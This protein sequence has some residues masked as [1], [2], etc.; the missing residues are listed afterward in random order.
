[1]RSKQPKLT[2]LAGLALVIALTIALTISLVACGGDIPDGKY[3]RKGSNKYWEFYGNKA[4]CYYN[5]DHVKKGTYEIDEDGLFV[6]KVEG[7][8]PEKF[9]FAIEGKELL[10]G[11][12]QYTRQ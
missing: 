3:V 1:M 7:E 5:N 2:F 8:K 9:L 6:F 11:T 12:T 10:L 4:M